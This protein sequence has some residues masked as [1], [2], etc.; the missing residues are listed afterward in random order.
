VAVTEKLA[1]SPRVQMVA[2]AGATRLAA[3]ARDELGATYPAPF[4]AMSFL[5]LSVLPEL[6]IT[7]R[8][9]VDTVRFEQVPLQA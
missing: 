5:A 2:L 3:A 7:D 6:R 9:L 8:G 4:M 1:V